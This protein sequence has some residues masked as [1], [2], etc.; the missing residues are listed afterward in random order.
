MTKRYFLLALSGLIL[1]MATG[2]VVMSLEY[3][4]TLPDPFSAHD[5]WYDLALIIPFICSMPGLAFTYLICNPP[6]GCYGDL[7]E[8]HLPIVLFNGLFWTVA[9]PVIWFYVSLALS[10]P[11]D[12]PYFYRRWNFYRELL[13]KQRR[14]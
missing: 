7:W 12:I 9:V 8:Y 13:K 1:G 14:S 6:D 10:F 4:D 3:L 2:S 5:H 11:R